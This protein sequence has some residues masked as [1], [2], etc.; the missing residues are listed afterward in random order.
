MADPPAAT[1]VA[2]RVEVGGAAAAAVGSHYDRLASRSHAVTFGVGDGDVRDVMG[3][4]VAVPELERRAQD[5]VDAAQRSHADIAD[6]VDD[7]GGEKLVKAVELAVVEQVAVQRDRLTDRPSVVGGQLHRPLLS[8]DLPPC[9]GDTVPGMSPERNPRSPAAGSRAPRAD[10]ERNR[11]ALIAAARHVFEHHGPA[12]RL[13]EI[14]R[15]AG[16]ANATLYRHFATRADL[17]VAVYAEEVAEL[18]A[19]ARRL[20]DADDPAQALTDWLLAFV[21]H[22]ATKRD[23]ALA[24]PDQPDGRRGALFDDWHAAMLAGAEGLLERARAANAVRSDIGAADLLAL[25]AGIALT[26]LPNDRLE[27]LLGLARHGYAIPRS[28]E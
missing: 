4:R 21:R 26:G 23:L 15:T 16:V 2:Q 18:D 27:G 8:G 11:A 6:V 14:A 20:R 9:A 19:S 28:P 12:A 1:F 7:I 13:D 24:L 17:I 22:V 5:L 3:E 10:A 25:A